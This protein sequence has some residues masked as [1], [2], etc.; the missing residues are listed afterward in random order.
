MEVSF[1]SLLSIDDDIFEVLATAGDTH[2]GGEDFD[3]HVIDYL[4]LQ[5][6]KKTGTGVLTNLCAMGKLKYEVEKAKRTLSN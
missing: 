3:N 5:H 2:L 1:M 6:K 4:V